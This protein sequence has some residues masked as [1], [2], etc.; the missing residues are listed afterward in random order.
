[1]NHENQ[2]FVKVVLDLLHQEHN[3]TIKQF[4]TEITPE[5]QMLSANVPKSILIYKAKITAIA[6]QNLCKSL[7]DAE[8]N[9]DATKK[10]EIMQ[11]IQILMHIRNS[12]SRELKRLTI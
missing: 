2:E 3:L 6:Y 5:E 8:K 9:E 7:S 4:V 10:E 12:F 1:M 11:Q